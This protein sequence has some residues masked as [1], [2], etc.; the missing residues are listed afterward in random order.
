MVEHLIGI[1][2][3]LGSQA[4]FFLLFFLAFFLNYFKIFNT[5]SIIVLSKLEGRGDRSHNSTTFAWW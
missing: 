2:K 4:L 1:Q 3:G 5:N